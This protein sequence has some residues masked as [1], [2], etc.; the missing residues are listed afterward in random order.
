MVYARIVC[1]SHCM[2]TGLYDLLMKIRILFFQ[3]VYDANK[4]AKLVRKRDRLR[5][6][7]DYNQLKFERHPDKRPTGKVTC[8]NSDGLACQIVDLCIFICE[9]IQTTVGVKLFNAIYA[10]HACCISGSLDTNMC[11]IYVCCQTEFYSSFCCIT[12]Q[13]L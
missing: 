4:F 7:L 2:K 8:E 1:L 12:M 11:S 9:A 10:N 13:M 5:N 3:A 6:W